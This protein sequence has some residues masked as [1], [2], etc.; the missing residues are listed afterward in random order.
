MSLLETLFGLLKTS[1]YEPRNG[2]NKRKERFVEMSNPDYGRVHDFEIEKEECVMEKIVTE[3][4]EEMSVVS[5]ELMEK[6]KDELQEELK[7]ELSNS[8]EDVKSE[9]QKQEKVLEEKIHVEN[10]KTYRNI[11]AGLEELDKKMAKADQLEKQ[12]ESLKIYVRCTTW[13][14]VITMIVLILYIM[15][16]IGV[17]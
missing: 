7:A 13:F 8:S 12:M 17:F 10:V 9:V 6:L 11:Q 16:S 2:K 14:S 5:K 1:S 15:Y 3:E 4:N